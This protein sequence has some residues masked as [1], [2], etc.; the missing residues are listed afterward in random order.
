MVLLVHKKLTTR[1]MHEGVEGTEHRP[2]RTEDD[3]SISG[4]E[5][6][7]SDKHRKKLAKPHTISADIGPHHGQLVDRCHPEHPCDRVP[8]VLPSAEVLAEPLAD[9]F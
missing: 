6:E 7:L 3:R 5:K 9:M 4:C 2:R 1:V 8:I